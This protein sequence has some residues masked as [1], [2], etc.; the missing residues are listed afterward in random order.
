MATGEGGCLWDSVKKA[1]AEELEGKSV[2]GA[3]AGR[4]G[5]GPPQLLL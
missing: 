1:V 4:K 2:L 3:R 5:T